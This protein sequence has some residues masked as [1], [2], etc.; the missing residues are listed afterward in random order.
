MSLPHSRCGR[1]RHAFGPRKRKLMV[2]PKAGTTK[3]P[4]LLDPAF[5]QILTRSQ[6]VRKV[7]TATAVAF[8]FIGLAAM[9]ARALS[10]ATLLAACFVPLEL[11]GQQAASQ[12]NIP[13]D[14]YTLGNGLKVVLSRDTTA[15]TAVVAVYYNIGFR[16]EPRNRP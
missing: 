6:F 14:Y 16:N 8:T 7:G 13:V 4:V 12:L 11:A 9:P 5:H 10:V 2:K 3:L 15:R 1:V